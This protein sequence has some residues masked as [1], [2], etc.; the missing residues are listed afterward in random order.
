MR[1]QIGEP[2]VMSHIHTIIYRFKREDD[3]VL[4]TRQVIMLPSMLFHVKAEQ[5]LRLGSDKQCSIMECQ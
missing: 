5:T 2:I 4:A 3:V 1:I